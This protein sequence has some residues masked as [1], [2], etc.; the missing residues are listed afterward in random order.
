MNAIQTLSLALGASWAAGINLYAAVLTIGI[1]GSYGAIHLP[2][3]LLLLQNPWVIA[4]AGFM[5]CVEFFADKV[6]GVDSAWDSIHTFIRI[7][8]GAVLAAQSL[9]NVDPAW[10]LAAGLIGGSIAAGSHA[11][12]AGTRLLINTSPEPF[13]N[14]AA[15]LLEDVAVIGGLWA[16]VHHPWVFIILLAS[17]LVLMA[18]ALPRIWKGVAGIISWI[19]SGFKKPPNVPV[20]VDGVNS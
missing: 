7:P 8:A 12:K 13:T 2:P 1:M 20:G 15:S 19:F 3:N 9:G 11:T 18:W 4:A 10:Q 5:F 14:I 17:V 6:P 16:A